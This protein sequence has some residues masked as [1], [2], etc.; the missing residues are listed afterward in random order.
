[1]SFFHYLSP[2]LSPR[3]VAVIGASERPGS[4]GEI[5]FRNLREGGFEGSIYPV[6]PRHRE[7]QGVPAYRDLAAIGAPVELAVVATPA[8]AVGAV[9]E[10]CGRQRVPAALVVTALEAGPAGGRRRGA[11]RLLEQAREHGV[12]LLGPGCFGV[13]RPELGLNATLGRYAAR[14]GRLALVSQSGALCAAIL[15]W[16][17]TQGLGFSSVIATGDGADVGLGEIL[18]FLVCDASTDG[19]LLFVEGIRDARGFLSGLRAA[20]RAKPITVMKA[21]R[22]PGGTP[23]GGADDCFE[24]ALARAGVVRAR[25]FAG[26]FAAARILASGLRL[27]GERLAVVSNGRGP[28][29]MAV[30]RLADLALPLPELS[31]K[32]ARALAGGGAR[33]PPLEVGGDAGPERYC[34][35]LAACLADPGVDAALAILTPQALADPTETARRVAG[36]AE[37]AGKPLLA[38]WMGESSVAAG[39]A[40]LRE[41]GVPEYR[42]PEAA[43]EA[44]HVLA[45]HH[46]NQRMLLQVPEPLAPGDPPDLEGAGMIVDAVLAEGRRVLGE[47]EAKAVLSAFRIPVAAAVTARDPVEALQLAAEIGFPVVMKISSPDIVDKSEV[48]GVRLNIR[49]A[50]ALRRAYEEMLERVRQARPEARIR[51][52]TLQRMQLR[53]HARELMVGVVRDPVFGPVLTFGL[54]GLAGEVL[55]ERSVALPP[56]NRFLVRELIAGSRAARALAAIGG[57]PAARVE[58]LE[59]LLLRVSE[60]VCEL[61]ALGELALDPLLVDEHGV[62]AVDARLSVERRSPALGRYGHMAIHPYPSDLVE[63]W[64]RPDGYQVVIRPIR[65]EDAAIEERFV[66][67]LSPESRYFRFMYALKELTPAMLSR[68]TQIDYDR[69]MALIAVIEERD[70]EREIGVARYIVNPDGRSCEFAVVVADEWQGKGV[71]S[72]LMTSLMRTA[73]ARRLE[74]IRGEVLSE[75]HN[76]LR[77]LRRLGFEIRQRP[78]DPE[79]Q[80]AWRRL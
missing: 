1:M 17:E 29:V 35:A 27:D 28:G 75:N 12:R 4:L 73:A 66:R 61:P 53:P 71:A 18:D 40:V 42:T 54:G 44:F 63:R 51:G 76:M 47:I 70:G 64:E 3:S 7:I 31:A 32:T 33:R 77:L 48:G 30:D 15:D 23:A 74:V 56:L 50:S 10:S 16:A 45:A 2:L 57:L 19:I 8:G 20:S 55:G 78:D 69:E 37:R 65:P 62:V 36:L 22:H 43:V 72:R 49:S 5:C 24:A 21:A 26:F 9:I 80:L 14:R 60:L 38:C 34:E 13:M 6:N 52:V 46:R 58:P 59:D 67:E 68:F 41:H 39:R 11:A 79:L 25:N